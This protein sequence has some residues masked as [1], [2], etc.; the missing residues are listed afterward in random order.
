MEVIS[1]GRLFIH[2]TVSLSS[3]RSSLM[4]LSGKSSIDFQKPSPFNYPGGLTR[5]G[6][7]SVV[8]REKKRETEDTGI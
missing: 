4:Q 8:K 7:R 6:G 5:A 2:C 1:S 3:C